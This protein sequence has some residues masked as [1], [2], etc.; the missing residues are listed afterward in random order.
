M[1]AVVTCLVQGVARQHVAHHI[2]LRV[3]AGPRFCKS[4]LH[5][6]V[7]QD[8][9]LGDVQR[10]ASKFEAYFIVNDVHLLF[11]LVKQPTTYHKVKFDRSC[12]LIEPRDARL[13]HE[14][15]DGNEGADNSRVGIA[16]H[17]FSVRFFQLSRVD[18]T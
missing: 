15:V 14:F 5:D 6:A 17:L 12:E 11:L 3:V 10:H 9:F 16:K 7:E 4:D 18:E 1:A 8:T 2:A 13:L